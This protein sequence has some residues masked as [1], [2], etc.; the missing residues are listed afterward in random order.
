MKKIGYILYYT[1]QAI[2]I[3]S[4]LAMIISLICFVWTGLFF[5]LQM[6]T[7]GAILLFIFDSL[8]NVIK[9]EY[10]I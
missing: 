6:I 3:I 1:F 5:Y 10:I 7:T 9:E 8:K 4:T 2:K